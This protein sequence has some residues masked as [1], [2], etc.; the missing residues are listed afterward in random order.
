MIKKKSSWQVSWPVLINLFSVV[1]E[2]TLKVFIYL[3]LRS[4]S[5][6][7]L[8]LLLFC[9]LKILSL[10]MFSFVQHKLISL[11][12]GSFNFPTEMTTLQKSTAQLW[13]I[14]SRLDMSEFSLSSGKPVMIV[15]EYME[16]GSLDGFLRVSVTHW[17]HLMRLH[18]VWSEERHRGLILKSF[19]NPS[20]S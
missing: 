16:N 14:F 2:L 8:N 9:S 5:S 7:P 19:K 15:T 6:M 18:Y 17:A 20:A 1:I 4:N 13:H 11:Q 3:N 12:I 10:K